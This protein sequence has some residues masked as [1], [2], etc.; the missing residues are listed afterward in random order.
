[1][2]DDEIE[3]EGQIRETKLGEIKERKKDLL[4]ILAKADLLS[5][6]IETAS[7]VADGC[8][9]SINAKLR[10]K[11]RNRQRF[12]IT[13]AVLEKTYRPYT[14]WPPEKVLRHM[15]IP[16]DDDNTNVPLDTITGWNRRDLYLGWHKNEACPVPRLYTT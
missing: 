15:K 8:T 4:E 9:A 11:S 3:L 2:L 6:G 14:D 16:T 12:A 5:T 1:M 13:K 10:T 7:T